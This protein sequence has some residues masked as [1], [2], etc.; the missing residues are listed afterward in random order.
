MV[1]KPSG[2]KRRPPIRNFI[3]KNDK[4]SVP[5]RLGL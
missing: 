3:R 4:K 1:K 5:E 2:N